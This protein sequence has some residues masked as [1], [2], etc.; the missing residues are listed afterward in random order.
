MAGHTL[1]LTRYELPAGARRVWPARNRVIY[2]LA[3]EV[4]IEAAETPAAVGADRAWHGSGAC[5]LRASAPGAVL[6]HWELVRDGGDAAASRGS[7][8]GSPGN[9]ALLLEQP[10][11]LDLSRPWLIR[12]DRVDF[13]PGGV[14]LPHGHRGG[15]IRCLI[16]GE[17]EVTVGDHPPRVMRPGSAWFESGREPVRAR[18][19]PAMPTSFIRVSILPGEIRGRSSIVYVDP[20]DAARG[21]P[22]KYTVHVDEPIELG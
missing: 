14:A 10:L 11:D 2:V 19:T 3:G 12:C 13:E 22:R 8:P 1:R 5:A 17:L 16:A 15:G 4:V 7:G 18:A 9:D 21:R 6:L 20:A